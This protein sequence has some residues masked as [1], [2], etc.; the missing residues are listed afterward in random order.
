MKI[1]FTT[2]HYAFRNYTTAKR[3]LKKAQ[4]FKSAWKREL[5]EILTID[6]E[7]FKVG[8]IADSK[9]EVIEALN[10]VIKAQNKIVNAANYKARKAERAAVAKMFAEVMGSTKRFK[11]INYEKFKRTNK[12]FLQI[13]R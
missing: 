12:R 9:A 7:M 13:C 6:G 4:Y 5:G 3:I 2:L 10:K 8:I 11:I 1:T